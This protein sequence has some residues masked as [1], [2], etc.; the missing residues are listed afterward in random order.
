MARFIGVKTKEG[1]RPCLIHDQVAQLHRA[2]EE[3]Q[4]LGP[5]ARICPH[6]TKEKDQDP[7]LRCH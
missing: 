2:M 7:E 5:Q 1:L 4:S 3:V 6:E